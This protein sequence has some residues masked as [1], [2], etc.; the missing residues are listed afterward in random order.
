[1]FA[2]CLNN[3]VVFKDSTGLLCSYIRPMKVTLIVGRG[4][5]RLSDYID[6]ITPVHIKEMEKKIGRIINKTLDG[7]GEAILG[8]IDRTM[9]VG[10]IPAVFGKAAISVPAVL[11]DLGVGFLFGAAHGLYEAIQEEIV[12]GKGK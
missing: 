10:A 3:P 9:F 4:E 1:M 2:Y 6:Y 11:I 7:A 5:P 8:D 12:H